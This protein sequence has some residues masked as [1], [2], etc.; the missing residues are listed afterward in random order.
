ML[1]RLALRAIPA[2]S[3]DEATER[4]LDGVQELLAA[5][6]FA[7]AATLA[8]A[9]LAE[10]PSPQQRARLLVAAG[11]ARRRVAAGPARRAFTEGL[12]LAQQQGDALLAA[13]AALG[14]AALG[15]GSVNRSLG[16]AAQKVVDALAAAE[17][18]LP[19][20]QADL[21]AQLLARLALERSWEPD[22]TG[23]LALLDR[24]RSSVTA[25]TPSLTRRVVEQAEIRVDADPARTEQRL[26]QA[27]RLLDEA[28][29]AHDGA[30]VVAALATRLPLLGELGR[31]RSVR[32]E[33]A[34]G[35]RVAEQLGDPRFLRWSGEAEAMLAGM[36]GDFARA[37]R[38]RAAALDAGGDQPVPSEPFALEQ[39]FH[40]LHRY[41]DLVEA[42]D[43]VALVEIAQRRPDLGAAR[44]CAAM[45]Q[46]ARGEEEAA[47]ALLATLPADRDGLAAL[48]RANGL[49]L[50][51]R[52][53]LAA[54]SWRLARAVACGAAGAAA[55]AV[56]RAPRRRLPA[57]LLRT[58]GRVA[59][60]A[61]AAAAATSRAGAS[62]CVRR[63]PRRRA[64]ARS[65]WPGASTRCSR[66]DAP[67]APAVAP[68]RRLREA[69]AAARSR[70]HARESASARELQGRSASCSRQRSSKRPRP[71]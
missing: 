6:D 12:R 65:S 25:E 18:A 63:A 10:H 51:T 37:R 60:A 55:G 15:E 70:H 49:A 52:C 71:S 66:P 21:H 3:A 69:P 14:L 20:D 27:G 39:L 8:D 47:R 22:P 19:P 53:A 35:Q 42:A 17:R 67:P 41:P 64:P 11:E 43:V 32:D 30:G 31:W 36:A 28:R 48:D 58:G 16:P 61:A 54:A 29:G 23:A 45:L 24:A 68:R 46:A 1:G 26:V 40:R 38:L 44:A 4:A 5:R 13:R 2:L 9:A 34:A 62:G 57:R 7:P 59:R 56:R 33:L 50:L